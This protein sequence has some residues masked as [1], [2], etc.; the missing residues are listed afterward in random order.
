MD[1]SGEAP[2]D[3][4]NRGDEKNKRKQTRKNELLA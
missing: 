1:I 4:G 3:N 2:T